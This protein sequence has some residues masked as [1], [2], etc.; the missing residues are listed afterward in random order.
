M[1]ARDCY[2]LLNLSS[3]SSW[4]E[5][6]SRFRTL[7]WE[8]H[9]D[10]HPDNPQAAARFRQLM[11][12]YEYLRGQKLKRKPGR[13]YYRGGIKVRDEVFEEFFGIVHRPPMSRSAGPD[14]RYDLR[15]PLAAALKGV[16]QTIEIPRFLACTACNRSGRRPGRQEVCP[17][18]QGRGRRPLGPGLLNKT[19]PV[20]RRCQGSG[21]LLRELCPVCEGV[22]YRVSRQCL[23]VK[24]PAGTEDGTRLRFLGQGGEGLFDGPAG[25]LEVVISVEPHEFF[26]R[27]G[28][29]LHCRFQVSFAQAALGGAVMVPTLDGERP[30]HLPQGTQSGQIFRFVGAGAPGG[31]HSPP[32]D[33]IIEVVVTTPEGLTA[34]QRRLLE[35]FAQLSG[36]PRS[37]A[38]H[39]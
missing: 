5:I 32:G 25:N 16:E 22:G 24:V 39:E 2:R 14:F 12:A 38:A 23:A 13:Q 7:V 30:L 28:N 34:A 21:E 26:A 1:T 4:D 17:E 36:Q 18:C 31:P 8:C 10:R 9:P 20:C 33:Q 27:K 35:E 29:D 15:I 6:K 37:L 11:A 19:G 3:R